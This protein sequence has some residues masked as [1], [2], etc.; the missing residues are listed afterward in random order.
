MPQSNFSGFKKIEY[1]EDLTG[2]FANPID[3]GIPLQDGS[4]YSPD[5]PVVAGAE[6]SQF[7]TGERE[8]YDLKFADL[9]KYAALET[10]MKADT[11]ITVRGTDMED[12]VNVIIISG[13]P[14]VKKD[15][16]FAVGNRN[17]YM[18]SIQEF[19]V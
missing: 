8:S 14:I 1:S 7:Y 5:R 16:P 13:I 4:Q 17:T 3:L 15:T 11:P 19:V 10:L 18:L 6:G 2:A 12:N 9:S